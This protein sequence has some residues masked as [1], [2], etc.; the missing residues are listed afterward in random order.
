MESFREN[1]FDASLNLRQYLHYPDH[2]ESAN[3]SL[4]LPH[5]DQIKLK[6]IR[7]L[8]SNHRIQI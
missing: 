8:Q 2:N 4:H 6:Q 1:N 5:G 7:Q 3:E